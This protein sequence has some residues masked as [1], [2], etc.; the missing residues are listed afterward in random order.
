MAVVA[1]GV[2]ITRALV[3]TLDLERLIYMLAVDVRVG[4]VCYIQASVE[5][6]IGRFSSVFTAAQ[7]LEKHALGICHQQHQG[8]HQSARSNPESAVI[9]AMTVQHIMSKPP[10]NKAAVMNFYPENLAELCSR[11]KG[12]TSR[13][14]GLR[15]RL[16]PTHLLLICN[17]MCIHSSITT[18]TPAFSISSIP[19]P[20]PC[21]AQSTRVL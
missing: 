18:C 4:N 16:Q 20:S 6:N 10:L 11:I 2:W 5:R 1:T 12:K 15:R 3:Q 7:Y 8:R 17:T 19:R 13:L 14:P 9:A 21:C